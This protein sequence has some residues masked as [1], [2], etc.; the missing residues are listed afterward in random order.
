MRPPKTHILLQLI[1]NIASRQSSQLINVEL[2]FQFKHDLLQVLFAQ[3]YRCA[4]NAIDR[5]TVSEFFYFIQ[6]N[7]YDKRATSTAA[8]I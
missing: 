6:T 2:R 1:V 8:A 5:L 7:N 4:S 3:R